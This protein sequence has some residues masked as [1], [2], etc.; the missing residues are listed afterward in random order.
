LVEARI[1]VEYRAEGRV[2]L[3]DRAGEVACRHSTVSL[4]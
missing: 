4:R 2:A 3:F 1:T